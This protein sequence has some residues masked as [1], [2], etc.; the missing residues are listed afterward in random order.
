MTSQRGFGL[1]AAG[2]CLLLLSGCGSWFGEA[3]EPPLPGKRVSIL[4][5]EGDL[6][7]DPSIS[8]Q[9]VA[10]PPSYLNASWTQVGGGSLHA[11]GHVTGP[12]KIVKPAWRS[13]IGSGAGRYRPLMSEPIVARD[14]VYTMDSK[15]RVSA[16][17]TANG[18]RIWRT[19]L[20]VPDRDGEVFGG[21]IAYDQGNIYVS[22]GFRTVTAIDAEDGALLWTKPVPGPVRA[23]PLVMD[24]QVFVVTVDNQLI[25]ADAAT[26]DRQWS[27]AG[28][29]EAAALLGSAAP[30]GLDGT[31]IVPY[32]SGEVFALRTANGR[33]TWSDNLA[34][35]RRVDTASTLADIRALPVTDGDFAYVISHSGRM[36]AID[37]RTGARAWERNIG[38]VRTP[39]IAGAWIFVLNNAAQIVCLSRRE[40]R[41]RWI[42]QLDKYENPEKLEDPIHWIG[43]MAIGGQLLVIGGH[44]R[45]LAVDPADGG[46]LD[47]FKLPKDVMAAALADGTLYLQTEDADLLAYR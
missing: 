13:S 37:L 16:Y 10:L 20:T 8:D 23:A 1:A 12:T 9:V 25:A 26:G 17:D 29:A 7:P 27:H 14:R 34:A 38:G 6:A 11:V 5:Y 31:V 36:V 35:V 43:P 4:L 32:S 46:I 47:N 39:W 21:G 19:R 41:V 28:F 22:S 44:G 30:A 3:D 18:K 45:G 15:Y 42:V 2:V 33:P 40:G 24:G